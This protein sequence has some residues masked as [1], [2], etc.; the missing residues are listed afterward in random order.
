MDDP[1]PQAGNVN[2][3]G[4]VIFFSY[5]IAA[6][7]LTG[8]IISDLYQQYKAHTKNEISKESQNSSHPTASPSRAPISTIRLCLSIFFA[9]LS[10]ATL[11]YHMLFFLVDSYRHYCISH[12]VPL[13]RDFTGLVNSI[14]FPTTASASLHIWEWAT[15]STLFQD[16]A[17]SILSS[18]RP[19][20]WTE[21]AL[22]YSFFW[23]SI[24]A[25]SGSKLSVP[26]LW[27]YF[28]L[29]QILP[30]SFTQNLFLIAA[31]LSSKASSTSMRYPKGTTQFSLL[32][33]YLVC[34]YSA[35]RTIN[36]AEFFPVLFAT[37]LLLFLPYLLIRSS[38][39]TTGPEDRLPT[40]PPKGDSQSYGLI[41][42]LVGAIIAELCMNFT[43]PN[44]FSLTAIDDNH[45]VSALSYDFLI[46]LGSLGLHSVLA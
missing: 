25:Y 44:E 17:H 40:G 31:Q 26:R 12:S 22:L 41:V 28:A 18:P 4:A 8:L 33:T 38:G 35:P 27:A 21:R 45:A 42:L 24:M 5:I 30:V 23:N 13:P 11:S 19:W 1:I 39:S 20:Y 16:F 14:L 15:H 7:L 37:R 34:L 46:G 2:I 10:F 6:L 43:G 9:V 3:I 36:T 29:D 32:M